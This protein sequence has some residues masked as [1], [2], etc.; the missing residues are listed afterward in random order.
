MNSNI[1]IGVFLLIAVIVTV[2]VLMTGKATKNTQ[3]KLISYFER[4]YP[5]GSWDKV[6]KLKLENLYFSLDSYYTNIISEYEAD[7]KTRLPDWSLDIYPNRFDIPKDEGYDWARLFDGSVCDCLRYA[8]P[9]CHEPDS[10]FSGKGVLV[11]CPTWDGIRIGKTYETT[12]MQ[13]FNTNNTDPNFIQE[14]KNTGKGFPNNSWVEGLSYPGEYGHP[15]ICG[16]P[17]KALQPGVEILGADGKYVSLNKKY[18]DG[19]WWGGGECAQNDFCKFGDKIGPDGT[20]VDGWQTCAT[21]KSNGEYPKG[22]TTE[23]RKMC[24]AKSDIP[25]VV[26]QYHSTFDEL[27]G[28]YE[29][30]MHHYFVGVD[31]DESATADTIFWVNQGGHQGGHH[32]GH[33]MEHFVDKTCANPPVNPC[34]PAS[35]DPVLNGFHGLWLYP[36]RGIGMWRNI[37]NSVVTNTKLGYLISPRLSRGGTTP[38]GCG[39][40]LED[41]ITMSGSGGGS[42]NLNKQLYQLIN[43]IQTGYQKKTREYPYMTLAT[44]AKHGGPKTKITDPTKARA[45]ALQL[46]RDWYTKGYSGITQ[47]ASPNGFNYNYNKFFPIGAHFSYAAALDNLVL[48]MMTID[49]VDTLQLLIEPQNSRAGLKPAYLFELFQATP[50]KTTVNNWSV[51]GNDFVQNQCKSFYMINP[52]DDEDNFMK[53]GYV[54]GKAVKTAPVIFDPTKMTL[55]ASKKSF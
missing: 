40:S 21:L 7:I 32:G 12:L 46:M 35:G 22:V 20:K 13:A 19:P 11:D 14:K 10:R 9:A 15:D 27:Y 55:T 34:S 18:S 51:F 39:F 29:P 48:Y 8:Y 24:I 2:V 43:I 26:E 25:K 28:G 31:T 45:A 4:L 17:S 49:K 16:S 42:Q 33:Y 53:Y 30:N 1:I 41:M 5:T 37:G 38:L 36:L 44:L 52:M 47:K 23:A 3:S 54:D 6:E 50:G